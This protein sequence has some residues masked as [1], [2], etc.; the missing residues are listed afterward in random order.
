MAIA[1]EQRKDN[2]VT[3]TITLAIAV[4][5]IG[6][7]LVGSASPSSARPV[8]SHAAVKASTSL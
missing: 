3:T 5:I 8:S 6:A 2:D 4:A 1:L 7:V